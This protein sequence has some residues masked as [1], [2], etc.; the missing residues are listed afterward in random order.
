MIAR[1]EVTHS[2]AKVRSFRAYR[3][4]KVKTTRRGE[5][6]RAIGHSPRWWKVQFANGVTGWIPRRYT[7]EVE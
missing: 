3:A 4:P 1:L 2:L 6:L 5:R 7:R